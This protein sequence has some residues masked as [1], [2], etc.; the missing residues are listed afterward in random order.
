M[1]LRRGLSNENARKKDGSDRDENGEMNVES[2]EGIRGTA[3]VT[4]VG[5]IK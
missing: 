4:Q 2:D 5:K 3:K 1:P